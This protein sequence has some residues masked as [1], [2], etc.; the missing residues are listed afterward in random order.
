M[1]LKIVLSVVALRNYVKGTGTE[2]S[3]GSETFLTLSI[4]NAYLR[5]K[6]SKKIL[7]S[8]SKEELSCATPDVQLHVKFLENS[9]G[10]MFSSLEFSI[11][12]ESRVCWP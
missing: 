2:A 4:T 5:E 11:V 1:C 6:S 7:M 8:V 12:L 9:M 10:G 3:V